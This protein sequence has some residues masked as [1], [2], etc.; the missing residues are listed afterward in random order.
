MVG[1][2]YLH[3]RLSHTSIVEDN[4]NQDVDSLPRTH[5]SSIFQCVSAGGGS[6]REEC[7]W[8]LEVSSVFQ[9]WFHRLEL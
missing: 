7:P 8:E 3:V 1:G 9:P 4:Q 2:L 5:Y 6:V